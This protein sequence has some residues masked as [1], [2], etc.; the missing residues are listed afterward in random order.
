M[1][2]LL[3]IRK[4]TTFSMK[5]NNLRNKYILD[6]HNPIHFVKRFIIRNEIREIAKI[7]QIE[8]IADIGCGFGVV[9]KELSQFGE[10]DGYDIDK[11]AIFLAKKKNGVNVN[12]F[13]LDLMKINKKNYYD[14]IVCS[15]VLQY[16]KNEDLFFKKIYSLLKQNGVLVLTV[17]INKN[18]ITDFDKREKSK[19]YNNEEITEKLEKNGFKI[20]KKR[21]W[22]Y[23]L[24]SLFYF[25]V[26]LPKS[27]KEAHRK[28]KYYNSSKFSLFV[29]RLAKYLFLFDLLF[30]SKKAFGLCMVAQKN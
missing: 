27:N 20:E 14:L 17:P 19:R 2:G 16:L 12:F 7:Y 25:F 22:G 9:S 3:H 30:N 1:S 5:N 26:Y 29:L 23:P 18:L 8:K 28:V 6:Q 15:E 11:N 10:I 21:F 4:L 13:Q 24:L